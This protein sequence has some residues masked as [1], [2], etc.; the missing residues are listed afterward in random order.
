MK[1]A[2]RRQEV[3]GAAKHRDAKDNQSCE[4][5]EGEL[6]ICHR[7]LRQYSDVFLSLS[8]MVIW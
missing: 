5:L 7:P 2:A 6:G 3:E 4:D 1:T 8:F